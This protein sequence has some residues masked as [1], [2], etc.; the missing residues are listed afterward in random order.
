MGPGRQRTA[1]KTAIRLG[2]IET[3][4]R[5]GGY[6]WNTR[7][8]TSV[9]PLNDDHGHGYGNDDEMLFNHSHS[10]TIQSNLNIL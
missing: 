1:T 3:T 9:F 5:G 2:F 7:V 10:E 6:A 8:Y 4:L